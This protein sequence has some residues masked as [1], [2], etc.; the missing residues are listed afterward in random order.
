[1]N[2]YITQRT[3]Y[4]KNADKKVKK[5]SLAIGHPYK[6]DENTWACAVQLKGLYENLADIC[7]EDSIQALM[8]AQNLA[9]TLLTDFVNKGGKIYSAEDHAVDVNGLFMS[10]I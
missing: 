2:T 9:R 1:M 6:K 7:G 10:G 3:L 8:L 4:L 5:I